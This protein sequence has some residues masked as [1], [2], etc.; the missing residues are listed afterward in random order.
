[1]KKTINTMFIIVCLAFVT[2]PLL[3]LERHEDVTSGIDNRTLVEAPEFGSDGYVADFEAYLQDRIGF[4]NKMVN[5]YD[6]INDKVFHELTHPIYTY[7]RDGYVFFKM[8]P[9]NPYGDYPKV[10]ADMVYKLQEYCESRGTKFYFIFD[11]EKISVYRN[12]LPKGVNYDDSWVDDMFSYMDEL[13][14][15]YVNNTQLLIDKSKNEQVFNKV[16]DAGHWNDLGMFYATNALWERIHEDI[17]S[18]TPMDESEF[19]ITKVEENVLPVSEFHISEQVP[20]FKLKQSFNKKAKEWFKEIRLHPLHQ[21]FTYEENTSV[22]AKN[23]PKIL[24]FQ[25]SYYNRKARFIVSR[26]S[27]Y[28]G[29]HNYQNVLDLPYYYNIFKPD[30]VILDAAEYVFTDDYFDSQKMKELNLNPSLIIE[31]SSFDVQ[32]NTLKETTSEYQSQIIANMIAGKKVDDIFLNQGINDVKYAYFLINDEVY[33]F[34]QAEDGALSLS[35]EHEKVRAGDSGIIIIERKDGSRIWT[36]TILKEA[37]PITAE[38]T[39]TKS[40]VIT[41]SKKGNKKIRLT[42]NVRGNSFSYITLQVYNT[43]TGAF[44]KNITTANEEGRKSGVYKH[45]L[46]SGNYKFMLKAN[47]N[48][49]DEGVSF[50][51]YLTKGKCYYYTFNINKLK[52]KEC[53]LNSFWIYCDAE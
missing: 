29:V 50:N 13:G 15:N 33:D 11:P 2:I 35:V 42:T 6:V 52:K 12:H 30:V 27:T 51:T 25:G 14:I 37:V 23:Y 10:F 49:V 36:S 31:P 20:K 18:V 44:I 4:R 16:Y 3:L 9:N 8:H 32:I 24:M 43:D 5:A 39:P 34:I 22:S 38:L 46:P 40:T 53:K 7:G 21:A 45:S 47:S 48:I 19:K 17:P 1:M 26:S 41:D 28:I